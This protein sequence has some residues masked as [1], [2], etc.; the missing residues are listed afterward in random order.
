MNSAD[1]MP[2]SKNAWWS[3]W[4]RRQFCNPLK[5][6]RSAALYASSTTKFDR[7]FGVSAHSLAGSYGVPTMSICHSPTKRARSSGGSVAT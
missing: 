4:P 1:G 7:P 3:L 6:K 5:P 2:T